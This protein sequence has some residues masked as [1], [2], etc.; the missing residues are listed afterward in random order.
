M[1]A[2]PL[3]L[4][5]E[6]DLHLRVVLTTTALA[7]LLGAGVAI[8]LWARRT[9]RIPDDEADDAE[10]PAVEHYRELLERGELEPDEFQKIKERLEASLPPEPLTPAPRP[11]GADTTDEQ[12]PGR[13]E[14]HP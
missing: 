13:D 3:P 4:F 10:E 12:A 1:P 8:A 5:A 6:I 2:H 7:V 14:P 9:W 11:P